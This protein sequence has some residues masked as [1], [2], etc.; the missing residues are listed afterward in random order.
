M[1]PL[2][3]PPKARKTL[4]YR[5]TGGETP[6]EFP[7]RDMGREAM[8]QVTAGVERCRKRPGT[9]AISAAASKCP[10]FTRCAVRTTL[11]GAATANGSIPPARRPDDLPLLPAAAKAVLVG[12][13]DFAPGVL[14]AG[15]GRSSEAVRQDGISRSRASPTG[16]GDGR[17]SVRGLP[18]DRRGDALPLS[19]LALRR[20]H[21]GRHPERHRRQREGRTGAGHRVRLRL[22]EHGILE[23]T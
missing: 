5:L 9:I 10:A 17:Q 16:M 12:G 20:A 6:E 7:L 19:A 13:D 11:G 23:P 22:A 18:H 1:N 8:Y 14:R 21:P 3:F 2:S 15:P 4:I